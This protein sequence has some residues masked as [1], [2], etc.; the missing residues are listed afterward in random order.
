MEIEQGCR[1]G[2]LRPNQRLTVA[3]SNLGG[4]L[5]D[6]LV[7]PNFCFKDVESKSTYTAP[8]R[9]VL[10]QVRPKTNLWGVLGI[11]GQ[12]Q[13]E[14]TT[15]ELFVMDIGGEGGGGVLDSLGTCQRN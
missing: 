3:G 1:E 15:C 6:G 4:V 2:D 12:L 7:D 5:E 11:W 9:W 14:R 8:A 10:G 13:L